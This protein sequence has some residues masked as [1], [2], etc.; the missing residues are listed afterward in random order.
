MSRNPNRSLRINADQLKVSWLRISA[1]FLPSQ[2]PSDICK[3]LPIHSGGTVSD[4]HW[5]PYQLLVF[6]FPAYY[7][8]SVS[9]WKSN[10]FYDWLSFFSMGITNTAL[11]D[12]YYTAEYWSSILVLY[13]QTWMCEQ[14]MPDDIFRKMISGF[15]PANFLLLSPLLAQQS[16][17]P[18]TGNQFPRWTFL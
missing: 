5:F 17:Y 3:M 6:S 13:N 10:I 7:N 1:F 11:C 4:S 9:E 18:V 8:I 16:F 2:F 12:R 15:S 14:H